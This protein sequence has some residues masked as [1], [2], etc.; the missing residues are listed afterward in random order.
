MLAVAAAIVV[1]VL[2]GACSSGSTVYDSIGQ[3]TNPG[4][5]RS[6]AAT[7]RGVYAYTPGEAIPGANDGPLD[8]NRFCGAVEGANTMSTCFLLDNQTMGFVGPTPPTT[9]K[10]LL[11][12]V[13]RYGTS[14]ENRAL[15]GEYFPGYFGAIFGQW[16]NSNCGESCPGR[17]TP[18]PFGGFAAMAFE[19]YSSKWGTNS[20]PKLI[21]VDPIFADSS[22]VTTSHSNY[23][24]GDDGSKCYPGDYFTCTF[25]D[26]WK[27]QGY[28]QRPRFIITNRPL[29]VEVRNSIGTSTT[30]VQLRLLSGPSVTNMVLDPRATSSNSGAIDMRGT[31]F[32][33]GYRSIQQVSTWQ[34]M[35]QVTD[36]NGSAV[37]NSTCRSCGTVITIVL[38][39]NPTPGEKTVDGRTVKE[40]NFDGSI[41]LVTNIS[42]NTSLTC[43]A[44]SFNGLVDG[45][46]VASV[47]I[48]DF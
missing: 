13:Q 48:K 17:L 37:S 38:R 9:D 45:S 36:A 33:G 8:V 25:T 19:P 41:C 12:T 21:G 28:F 34:A 11:L 7:D 43:D 42:S 16:Q 6:A 14:S 15:F 20:S 30:P 31:G 3:R 2:A 47:N 24:Y 5:G 26:E 27:T 29:S 18:N 23:G 35:Y 1:A 4:A 22:P 44:P 39:V 32:F 40:T 46:L 10:R